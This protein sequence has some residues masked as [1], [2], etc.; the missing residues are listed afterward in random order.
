MFSKFSPQCIHW[1]SALSTHVMSFLPW[2]S[3][4]TLLQYADILFHFVYRF[5]GD[6]N[7]LRRQFVKDKTTKYLSHAERL[8]TTYLN[9]PNCEVRLSLNIVEYNYYLYIIVCLLCVQMPESKYYVEVKSKYSMKKCDVSEL[10]KPY[11]ELAKYRVLGVIGEQV[12][13]VLSS[14]AQECHAMKVLLLIIIC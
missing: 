4:I 3:H 5:K 7:E 6:T 1:F 8:Y 14:E 10:C 12:L 2:T 11:Q 13:L 9:D